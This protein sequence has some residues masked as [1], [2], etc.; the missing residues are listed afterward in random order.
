MVTMNPVYRRWLT[1]NPVVLTKP[2]DRPRFYQ[3]WLESNPVMLTVTQVQPRYY[4]LQNA[5]NA[6]SSTKN[7]C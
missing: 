3:L 6:N 7:S 4:G 1:S 2:H 5:S